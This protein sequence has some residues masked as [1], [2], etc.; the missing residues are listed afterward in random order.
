[1]DELSVAAVIPVYNGEAFLRRAV[2]SVRAQT[3]APA[4][5]LLVDDCSTDGT[6]ALARELAGSDPRIRLLEL[7]R[8]AGPSAARN[9]AL[10]SLTEPCV[11]FLDADDEWL[12]QH[13]AMLHHAIS[14]IP[15]SVLAF[16]RARW[17][18][19][20]PISAMRVAPNI[21][22]SFP[23]LLRENYIV[24]S[25]VMVDRL[26]VLG[27]GGYREDMRYGEDYD[28]WVRL[29]L[30][31]GVF[32]EVDAT[33]CL[34][35]PHAGQVSQSNAGRM[36]HSAWS[37]RE[38]A[39]RAHYGDPASMPSEARAAL[40]AAMQEDLEGAW[41]TRSREVLVGALSAM[42]WVPQSEAELSGWRARTG[43]AWYFWRAAAALWDAAP[44]ALKRMARKQV[45]V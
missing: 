15:R 20:R 4:T 45:S 25:A 9:I 13:V 27:V 30:A 38:R 23:R 28:L 33:G 35:T 7:A 32:A 22:E 39:V 8:N 11:A 14:T 43:R 1:M 19:H 40:A 42:A 5:I 37:T 3:T 36:Y 26:A 29:A 34:R 18:P 12:P 17:L 31:G 6:V 41:H 21:A 2:A 24:Q 16:N 10:R 44:S